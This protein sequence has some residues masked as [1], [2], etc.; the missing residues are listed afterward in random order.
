MPE[1][2]L[3]FLNN[4]LNI[5]HISE[6]MLTLLLTIEKNLQAAWQICRIAWMG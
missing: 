6:K 1:F 2:V 5:V 3:P 4:F